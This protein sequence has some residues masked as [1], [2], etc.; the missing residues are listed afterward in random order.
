MTGTISELLV[1]LKDGLAAIYA[2]RL[3]GIYVYGSHARG[4]A[5]NDSDLD[6]LIVLD[7]IDGYGA[8]IDRTS[9]LVSDISLDYGI[10]V[11]RVFVGLEEWERGTSTF[12]RNARREARAA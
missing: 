9:H 3:R 11:S 5:D 4:E 2:D 6:I 1:A 12:L 8:E 7:R 10:S